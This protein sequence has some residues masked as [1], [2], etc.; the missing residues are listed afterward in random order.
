ML[1]RITEVPPQL[2][3]HSKFAIGDTAIR[4]LLGNVIARLLSHGA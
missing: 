4:G 3:G 1:G 2:A